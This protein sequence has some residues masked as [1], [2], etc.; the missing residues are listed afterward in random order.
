MAGSTDGSGG[1][2]VLLPEPRNKATL[3]EMVGNK[4]HGWRLQKLAPLTID[5]LDEAIQEYHRK[6]NP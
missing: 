3:V 6:G 2:A 4:M 1:N 5:A